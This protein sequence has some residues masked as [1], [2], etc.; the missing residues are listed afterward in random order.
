MTALPIPEFKLH[1]P[2]ELAGYLRSAQTWKE[3]EA[4]TADYPQW[5]AQA[6]ELLSGGDRDRIK[7]LKQWADCPI[8]KQFPLG[9]IVQRLDDPESQSGEAIAY[10]HAYGIDYITFRVGDDIDWC[11]ASHLQLKH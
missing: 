3:I 2:Q 11:R 10:W 5:K 8:A 6:W 1:D 9:S 7:L 4:L